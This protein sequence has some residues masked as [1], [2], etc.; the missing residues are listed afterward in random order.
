[1][2][3]KLLTILLFL[4]AG[5]LLLAGCSASSG[6]YRYNSSTNGDDSSNSV[7]RFES[8]QVNPD[9][10]LPED[11]VDDSE[12]LPEELEVE[13]TEVIHN[14]SSSVPDGDVSAD[15]FNKREQLLM[16]IIKYLDTPYKYGGNNVNGIDCSGFTKNV[17]ESTFG[18]TLERSARGQFT[19]GTPINEKNELEFG[20][21]VFFNTRRN[22]KPGHVGI[23]IGD[24]LF[25]HASSK[26][27]V[28]ISSLNHN[29]YSNRF[30]GGRRLNNGNL[31]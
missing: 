6:S 5:L 24:D 22:V 11:L 12:E 26:H 29:Y 25:A 31:Y 9:E 1:M 15:Q 28:I 21:L 16:E 10:L 4:T 2:K 30:M 17:F 8:E 7:I 27:G 3:T 13:I 20:D 18:I 19:Q 14:L 23:Y